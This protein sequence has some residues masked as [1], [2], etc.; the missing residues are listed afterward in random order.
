MGGG[1]AGRTGAT[2]VVSTADGGDWRWKG[3]K[4]VADTSW[5]RW[6]IYAITG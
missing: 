3:R 1:L 6:S 4:V 2:P 5:V